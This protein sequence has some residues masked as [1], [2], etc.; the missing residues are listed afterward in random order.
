MRWIE[1]E[2]WTTENAEGAELGWR[3]EG[4]NLADFTNLG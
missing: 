1:E 2:R 3:E 4:A